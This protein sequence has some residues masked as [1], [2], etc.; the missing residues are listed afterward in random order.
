[1][2][3]RPALCVLALT[4]LIT[5]AAAVRSAE[6]VPAETVQSADTASAGGYCLRDWQGYV[7]VFEGESET[8][9]ELTDI[10]TGTLNLVDREKLRSGIAAGTR[11][12]LL[13]LLEDFSS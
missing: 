3:K 9:S 12:Q 11:E 8:P 10:P 13:S 4:A 1:M 2:L 7:A 5:A 6:R